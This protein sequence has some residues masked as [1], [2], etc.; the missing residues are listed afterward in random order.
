MKKL[1][2]LWVAALIALTAPTGCRTSPAK[3]GANVSDA[4]K[5]T[6]ETSLAVWNDYIPVGKPSLADQTKVRD[7]Y[8]RYKQ[9]QLDTLDAALMVKASESVDGPDQDTAS[10]LLAIYAAELTAASVDLINL[11][12]DLS[13]P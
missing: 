12:H 9:A 4:S 13:T 1:F 6:V 3:V 2:V 8:K 10:A 7:A 11:I 5:V